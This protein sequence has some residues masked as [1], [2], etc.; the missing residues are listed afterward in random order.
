MQRELIR[1][2]LISEQHGELNLM[3]EK[4]T[5]EARKELGREGEQLLSQPQVALFKFEGMNED[6]CLIA[7]GKSSIFL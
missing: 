4:L 2:E 5:I 1:Q 7:S 3:N 6:Q